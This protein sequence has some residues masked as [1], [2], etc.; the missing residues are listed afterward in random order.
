MKKRLDVILVERGLIAT[1]EK[2]RRM[3]MAGRVSV[4]GKLADKPG[5]FFGEDVKIDIRPVEEEYV[6]RGGRKLAGALDAFGVD[7]AGKVA[8]DVGASTGGFTDCLLKRGATRVYAVDVGYGQIDDQLRKDERVRLIERTNIRYMERE[9]IP[10]EID[11]ATVDTSFISLR[12]VLPRVAS[13][14]KPAGEIIALIK[15]QFELDPRDVGKGVV[16]D[17]EKRNRAVKKIAG[18]AIELG[19][20]TVGISQSTVSGAKG[21]VEYFI[22]LINRGKNGR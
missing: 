7:P 2:A 16:R 8:L 5:H 15:P 11:L 13:F 9:K 3:V 4:D 21:N 22:Y 1:R 18:A 12:L 6:S 20:E 14:V 10:E 17:P 19:M